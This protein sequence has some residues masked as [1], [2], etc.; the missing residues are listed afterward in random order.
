MNI[1][2]LWTTA[3]RSGDYNQ[4]QLHLRAYDRFCC[5]GVLC[6]LAVK[7]GIISEPIGVSIYAY[8]GSEVSVP[9]AVMEWAGLSH[10][11]GQFPGAPDVPDDS[12][13]SM[14]DRGVSFSAIADLIDSRPDG[15][16]RD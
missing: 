12:L 7:N 10:A 6:D 14:N 3:L 5:L 8:D 16:F 1:A 9:L 13:T 11:D 15:L 4:G 2:K